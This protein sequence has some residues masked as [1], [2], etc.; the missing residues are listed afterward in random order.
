[1]I[2]KMLTWYFTKMFSLLDSLMDI[3]WDAMSKVDTLGKM[4]KRMNEYEDV[5]KNEKN[6]RESE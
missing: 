2:K 4:E 6:E 1:M 3:M 5:E